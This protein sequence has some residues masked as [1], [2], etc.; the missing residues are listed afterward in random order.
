MWR[1]DFKKVLNDSGSLEAQ[2]EV[3]SKESSH[4]NELMNECLTRKEVEQALGSLK[5]K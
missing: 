1:K 4:G 3:G 2:D 5:K